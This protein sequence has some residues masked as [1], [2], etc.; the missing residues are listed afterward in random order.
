VENASS[1]TRDPGCADRCA[2]RIIVCLALSCLLG[3]ASLAQKSTQPD[4]SPWPQIRPD[5]RVE[6]LRTRMVEYSITFAAQVDFASTAIERRA[7]DTTVQRNALLWRLRAIPEMHKACFRLEAVSAL[8]DAWIF[9]RQM[10]QLFSEGAGAG[11]FGSFQ[12]EVIEV[13]RRLVD[14][15]REIGDSIAVS[16]AARTEFEHTVIDPW[17]AEHPL[18]DINFVRESPIARFAEQSRAGGDTFQSVGTM[19]E[20]AVSL[21]RQARIYLAD[22]PRQ[23][24]GEIDLMRS[25]MLPA[26]SLASMQ[27]D[28]HLSAAAADRLATAAEGILP[29]ALSERHI[30]L[31]EMNRQRAL[32]MAALSVERERAVDGIIQAFAAE[33][34]EL[35]LNLESQRLATLEWATAERRE[36]TAEVRRELAASIDALR[37]ERA[38]V[39]DDLRHIV[40]RVLL[41]VAI[42]ILA[43]VMLAPFIAHVYARVWPRRWREP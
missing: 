9:A 23:V 5:F 7:A 19:E 32:V 3:C 36:A 37:G 42:F 35:L 16:P 15:L 43:A 25:D 6:T 1:G 13:S 20:L 2:A 11:A 40:D 10:D 33:R 24:R 21:S 29:M 14:Q 38:V 8:I 12:P 34:R 26:E 30:V 28:L 41:R 39:V 27:R 31:E 17:L 4:L 22:L 18:R